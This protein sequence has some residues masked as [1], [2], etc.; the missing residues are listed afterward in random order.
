MSSG[1]NGTSASKNNGKEWEVMIQEQSS[2]CKTTYQS[3][4]QQN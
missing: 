3:K 1:L 2:A 4:K